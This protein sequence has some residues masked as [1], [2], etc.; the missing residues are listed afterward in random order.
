M[1][2]STT[3]QANAATSCAG[4]RDSAAA[5]PTPA[6]AKTELRRNAAAPGWSRDR[7]QRPDAARDLQKHLFEVGAAV[8]VDQLVRAAAVHNAALL[9]H[10]DFGAQP[11]DLGHV[12]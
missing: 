1:S 9:H 6:P 3:A 8:A 2:A 12:V 7:L 5:S 11:L 10:H 4:C